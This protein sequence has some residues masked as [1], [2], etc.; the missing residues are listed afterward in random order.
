V[1]LKSFIQNNVYQI[2]KLKLN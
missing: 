2:H 1:I